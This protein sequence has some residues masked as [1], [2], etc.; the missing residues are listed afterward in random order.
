[1]K[2]ISI[3][4][5]NKQIIIKIKKEDNDFTWI[6]LAR[7]FYYA[8]KGLSYSPNKLDEFLEELEDLK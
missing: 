1:M 8:L 7:D 3:E 5:E 4:D 6:Q 2:Q